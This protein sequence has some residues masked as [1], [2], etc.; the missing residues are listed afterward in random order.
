MMDYIIKRKNDPKMYIVPNGYKVVRRY[1]KTVNVPDETIPY[2]QPVLQSNGIYGEGDFSVKGEN[3]TGMAEASPIYYALDNNTGNYW[4]SSIGRYKVYFYFRN[5][6][7]ISSIVFS[8]GG[9]YTPKT[10]NSYG[11]VNGSQ[12]AQLGSYSGDT[13]SNKTV[14]LNVNSSEFYR[15]YYIYVENSIYGETPYAAWN[16][17]KITINAEEF[18]REAYSYEI[19]VAEGEEYDRMEETKTLSRLEVKRK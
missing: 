3:D 2:V 19:E 5:Q 8:A 13:G 7:K 17:P 11:S 15:Y 14:I 12:W 16:V 6:I 1:Y 9:T 4:I 10:I 18:V